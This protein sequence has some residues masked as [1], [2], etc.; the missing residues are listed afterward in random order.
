MSFEQTRKS[1][2]RRCVNCGRLLPLMGKK[3]KYCSDK[4]SKEATKKRKLALDKGM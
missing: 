2:N 1:L 4:C 3:H